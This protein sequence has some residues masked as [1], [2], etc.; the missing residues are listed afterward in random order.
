[1]PIFVCFWYSRRATLRFFVPFAA[2]CILLCLVP[3]ITFP[4]SFIKN[5]VAYGSIWGLWGI[6]FWL[7]LTGI[8]D[9]CLVDY[10][11][12]TLAENI[13]GTALKALIVASVIVLAWAK[14]ERLRIIQI[15]CVRVDR[16]LPLYPWCGCAIHGVDGTIRHTLVAS[17]VRLPYIE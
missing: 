10:H 9:F 7:R 13:V 12:L 5:V 17:H 16:F 14:S 8:H 15:D 11:D 4:V 6:S 2:A 1:L 3:V